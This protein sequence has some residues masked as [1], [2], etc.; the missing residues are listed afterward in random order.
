MFTAEIGGDD[1]E[2]N[3]AVA[4]AGSNDDGELMVMLMIMIMLMMRIVEGVLVERQDAC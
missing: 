4:S 2:N 3:T 1:A